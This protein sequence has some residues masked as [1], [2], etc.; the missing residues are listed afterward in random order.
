LANFGDV[1]DLAYY[2][3]WTPANS[4]DLFA[5]SLQKAAIT[6]EFL[7]Y[8]HVKPVKLQWEVL[9]KPAG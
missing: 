6:M 2:P 9:L 7:G 3:P 1:S 8:S 4:Y 5:P